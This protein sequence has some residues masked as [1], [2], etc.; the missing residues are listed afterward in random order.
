MIKI[1]NFYFGN[2]LFRYHFAI[3]ISLITNKFCRGLDLLL[4]PHSDT[5]FKSYENFRKFQIFSFSISSGMTIHY[6]WSAYF[7]FSTRVTTS[8]ALRFS[9]F[10]RSLKP[11]KYEVHFMAP[12][13]PQWKLSD[14][15]IF[16]LQAAQNN[17]SVREMFLK[18]NFTFEL[19]IRWIPRT[20]S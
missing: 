14:F 19:P 18:K 16:P 11:Q 2:W 5:K 12:T 6:E 17:I 10:G 8:V 3:F 20:A 13:N 1:E 4:T 7:T 9:F 15:L